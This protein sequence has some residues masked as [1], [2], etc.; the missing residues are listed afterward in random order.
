[1]KGSL[2]IS[3]NRN[4]LWKS[5]VAWGGLSLLKYLITVIE[6]VFFQKCCAIT[7]IITYTV[8]LPW[9]PKNGC[10]IEWSFISRDFTAKGIVWFNRRKSSKNLALILLRLCHK[11]VTTPHWTGG[12]TCHP[13]YEETAPKHWKWFRVQHSH[14]EGIDWPWQTALL[15]TLF[16]MEGYLWY[17]YFLIEWLWSQLLIKGNRPLWYL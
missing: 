8:W 10:S 9:P 4:G 6:Y 5:Q 2:E 1:M 16:L 14:G 11:K 15:L 13:S 3:N 17:I 7:Y 12:G